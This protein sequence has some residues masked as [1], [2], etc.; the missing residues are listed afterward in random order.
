MTSVSAIKPFASARSKYASVARRVSLGLSAC[1]VASVMAAPVQAQGSK[2]GFVNLDRILR[3]SSPAKAAQIK[4]ESEFKSR[5]DEI[6][7]LANTLRSEYQ[8]L[9]KDGPVLSESDRVKR[10]RNIS[11]MDVDLQRKQRE[12]QED[13]NRRRNEEFG[14]IIDNTN[15][16]IQR[17][18][19]QQN[20][21]LILQNAVTVNPR[22]DITD[23][24]IQAMGK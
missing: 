4:L 3:D 5:D 15:A 16:A 18:A 13:L 24:V 8:K 10:E 23:Q 22:V 9:D 6:Q 19:E 1:L 14:N 17:I 20:Y 2:V 12:F 7:R 21:D 11:N